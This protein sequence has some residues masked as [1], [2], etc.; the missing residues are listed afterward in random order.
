[1]R[2]AL[3]ALVVCA[4]MISAFTMASAVSAKHVRAPADTFISVT[5]TKTQATWE[6]PIPL[7]AR[8][9]YEGKPGGGVPVTFQRTVDPMGGKQEKT[10]YNLGQVVTNQEGVAQLDAKALYGLAGNYGFRAVYGQD[11]YVVSNVWWVV[12]KGG[13]A[14]S[15][16]AEGPFQY[17]AVGKLTDQFGY[18]IGN[19]LLDITV[20]YS[21]SSP[22]H[23]MVKTGSDGSYKVPYKV[24]D[25][26]G[27]RT[28][29]VEYKGTSQFWGATAHVRLPE[30]WLPPT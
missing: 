19:A 30:D 9:T 18:P 14:L 22:S 8:F 4:V 11:N 12:C 24:V 1:M 15:A 13:T 20:Y 23:A 17:T 27:G 2:K 26:A 5:S 10:W 28:V 16:K 3:M 29:Y 7:T 25:K 6:E 21:A